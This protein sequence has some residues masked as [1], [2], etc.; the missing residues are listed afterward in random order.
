MKISR[1]LFFCSLLVF[2]LSAFSTHKYYLSLTEIEFNKDKASVE[3][4]MNVFIDDIELVLNKKHAID[5]R[6]NTPKE[7]LKNDAYFKSYIKNKMIIKVDGLQK[8]LH[9]L[10]KEYEGDLVYFYIEI[11]ET[12][13]FNTIEITNQMLT[14]EFSDQQNLIKI[15]KGNQHKSVLLTQENDKALLKF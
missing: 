11:K 6:L 15:K 8:E 13:T 4:I 10:G 9:Y 1:F 2:M 12:P 5:L 3:I 7:F 14:K